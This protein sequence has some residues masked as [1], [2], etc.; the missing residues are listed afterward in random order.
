VTFNDLDHIEDAPL[1]SI[2]LA[3]TWYVPSLLHACDAL[4]TE[5][6]LT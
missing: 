2:A 3:L 1:L 6:E 4:S 5:P